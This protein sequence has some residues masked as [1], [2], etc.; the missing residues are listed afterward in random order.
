[1][2]NSL[3]SPLQ[4][5]QRKHI[6]F[7]KLLVHLSHK[8]NELFVDKYRAVRSCVIF[9]ANHRSHEGPLCLR[10]L[11]LLQHSSVS[12]C[13]R[14]T[15]ELQRIVSNRYHGRVIPTAVSIVPLPDESHHSDECGSTKRPLQESQKSTG[16]ESPNKQSRWTPQLSICRRCQLTTF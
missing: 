3:V 16:R 12:L 7:I 1:M 5:P 8:N 13:K 2:G 15:A 11:C 10:N 4:R 6:V 14:S 9:W